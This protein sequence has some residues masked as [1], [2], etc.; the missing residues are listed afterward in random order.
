M[1][2]SLIL[3]LGVYV[4]FA[5]PSRPQGLLLKID[6]M[7]VCCRISVRSPSC[8][9]RSGFAAGCVLAGAFTQ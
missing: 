4:R 8:I 2:V 3:F 7:K 9:S 6:G 1:A 5:A